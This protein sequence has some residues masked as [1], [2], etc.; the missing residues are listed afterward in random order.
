MKIIKIF[1][2]DNRHKQGFVEPLLRHSTNTDHKLDRS[3]ER[4]HKRMSLPGLDSLAQ[5]A[6][7][8]T[9]TLQDHKPEFKGRS[10]RLKRKGSNL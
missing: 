8:S 9:Q 1:W 2:R 10:A 4:P 3:I 5:R 6:G 7:R